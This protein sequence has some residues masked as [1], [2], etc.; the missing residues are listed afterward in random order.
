[1]KVILLIAIVAMFGFHMFEVYHL[2]I[3]VKDNHEEF[4]VIVK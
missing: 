4:E 1:M 3:E 2:D